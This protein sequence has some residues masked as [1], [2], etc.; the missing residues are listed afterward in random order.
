RQADAPQTF[1]ARRQ[2]LFGRRGPGWVEREEARQNGPGGFAGELLIH[3]GA[4]ERL[5]MRSLGPRL[6]ATRADGLDHFREDRVGALEV[7]DGCS[8]VSHPDN[9]R[10]RET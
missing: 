9:L 6:K 3:D 7:S 4:R 10:P 8:G 2:H 1:L 5:V